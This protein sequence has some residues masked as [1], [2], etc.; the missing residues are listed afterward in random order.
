M[1]E[2]NVYDIETF[3]NNGIVTPY[4]ISFILN[5]KLFTL[6]YSEKN[7]IL[8]SL[9]IIVDSTNEDYIEIF[10]HNLNF[11]GIIIINEI[12]KKKIKFI[13]K[14]KSLNLYYIDIFF[15]N[16]IIKFRCSYKLLNLSLSAL[17]EIEKHPK[18]F[19]PHK[20][21][22]LST[23]LYIGIKPDQTYWN[24]LEEYNSVFTED[25]YSVKNE[26]IKYC[27]NDV[28]L[29]KKVLENII[30]II[31][32]ECNNLLKY[33]FSS[34]SLS[35]KIFIK[36]Y[37]YNNIDT[38]LNKIDE[39]YVRSAYYGGRCEVFGNPTNDE[40]I[41]YYD[42][43]GMYGQCMLEKFHIGAGK[44]YTNS[45]I[46]LPGFHTILYWSNFNLPI[47][48]HH[49]STGK[50]LFTN[51]L[52]VGT[53]WF[54][55]IKNF[56]DNGGIVKKIITSYIYNNFDYVFDKFVNSF[57][58]IKKKN[59]YYKLFGKLMINSLYGSMA[60]ED[61]NLLSHF[62]WDE[63]EANILLKTTN[64]EK[65]YNINDLF[66]LLIKKDYKSEKIFKKQKS[67]PS[68]NVSYAAAISS[69]A[70]IK[71]YNAFLEVI[72]D[73]GR[74]LYCDTD[75]IFAAYDIKKVKHSKL[76]FEWIEEYSDGVFI[77]PKSYGLK[78]K[79]EIIKIKG[80]GIKKLSFNDLKNKFYNNEN[81]LFE[82]QLM[83]AHNNFELNQ[84]YI[85]KNISLSNYDKRIFINN[86]KKTI[87]LI[88]NTNNPYI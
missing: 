19:F 60:L 85:T 46:N 44:Y 9:K 28:I 78:G 72:K 67:P 39:S 34:P 18:M 1:K 20:F 33:S 17:G 48:P 11:D 76:S 77:S 63:E 84:K 21:I 62:T 73:G 70:R 8:E 29:T 66:F 81:I 61:D 58:E 43:S 3:Q 2:V 41:K 80:V 27:E 83:F 79:N 40:I 10:V 36:K 22:S 88:I 50:L 7:I 37:N 26:C 47:L 31:V 53:H 35:Y 68:R 57:N 51:G 49:S 25:N 56:V 75:S 23:L 55:E 12:S 16:K 5:N 74:L 64:V 32:K 65:F 14:S 87:P 6:Y 52:M 42:F 59:G 38:I 54:E 13:F 69:K 4:C 24:S 71:L 45:D 30:K 82:N 86:K 15:M